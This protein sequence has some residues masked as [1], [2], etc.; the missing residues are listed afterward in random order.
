MKILIV[1]DEP[2]N[3]KIY[4]M[5]LIKAGFEVEMVAD[6]S[7]AFQLIHT[8]QFDLVVLDV[9]LPHMDGLAMLRRLRAQKRF[10]TLPFLV[11]TA[12]DKG[13]IVPQAMAAGAN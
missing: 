4:S 1:E 12:L 3:S 13:T 6:G 8:K 10:Q 11:I 7:E 5:A 9:M 2:I